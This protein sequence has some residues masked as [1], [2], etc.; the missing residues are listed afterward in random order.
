M[1][2]ILSVYLCI[3]LIVV[4]LPVGSSAFQ[5]D[6]TEIAVKIGDEILPLPDYPVG[7][8]CEEERY[9]PLPDGGTVDVLGWECIGFARYVFY[10]CFG[11]V[12]FKD[13]G[14]SGYHCAVYRCRGD[15]LTEEYLRSVI[16]TVVLP[17]A[18]I[19]ASNGYKGHSMILLSFDDEYI[20]TYEGNYDWNNGVTVNQRTWEEFVTYCAKKGGI[21][22]IHMPDTYPGW[23]PTDPPEPTEPNVTEP[24]EPEPT[25]APPEPTTTEPEPTE[26]E[27]T[28]PTEPPLDFSDIY[29]D[30]P[31]KTNWAYEGMRFMLEQGLLVGTTQ[32]QVSPNMKMSRAML[33]TVLWRMAGSPYADA[34]QSFKDVKSTDWFAPAV[35]WASQEGVVSG[36]GNGKFQP[37]ATVTREQIASILY[38]YT[39]ACTDIQTALCDTDAVLAPF[40]DR[41]RVSSW[42]RD[43]VAWAV[44]YGLVSGKGSGGQ[45]LLDPASGGTRA[46]VASIVMRFFALIEQ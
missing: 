29:S 10:R 9:Y 19:R 27:P 37:N 8:K 39:D 46:E 18:H 4:L 2:R 44:N 21:E 34:G 25:T 42:A 38:R 16:G 28:E 23:E 11:V 30:M 33:V 5:T 12:D 26:P 3:C 13:E 17:G 22:F 14:G 32:T 7:G 1:K 41:R 36:V 31:A 35:A 6:Y 15:D 24:T 20:Y 40:P 43:S 45:T